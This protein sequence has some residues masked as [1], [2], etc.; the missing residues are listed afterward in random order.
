MDD[1]ICT[2]LMDTRGDR[3]TAEDLQ[4]VIRAW[5]DGIGSARPTTKNNFQLHRDKGHIFTSHM[6]IATG[7]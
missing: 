4:F 6:H 5:H 3:A 2:C 1:M 7:H